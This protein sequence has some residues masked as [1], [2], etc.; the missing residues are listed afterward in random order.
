MGG[1]AVM[2]FMGNLKVKVLS[3]LQGMVNGAITLINGFITDVNKIPGVNIELI[4]GVTFGTDAAIKNYAAQNARNN[5]IGAAQ[6]QADLAAIERR[7]NIGTAQA[8]ARTANV[9]TGLGADVAT[10]AANTG[11]MADSMDASSEELKYLRDLA[12][13]EVVNRFTTAEISVNQNNTFG[14]IHETADLDGV[15]SYFGEALNQTLASAA[16]GV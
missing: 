3:D 8:A 14:D 11:S 10:I 4:S 12:E 2:T 6:V 5:V 7:T 1:N 16:E 9:D 13:M 15:I